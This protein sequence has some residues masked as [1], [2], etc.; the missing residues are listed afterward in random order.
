VTIRHTVGQA[1][2]E[3]LVF[4]IVTSTALHLPMAVPAAGVPGDDAASA[5]D[6]PLQ[7]LTC[8]GRTPAVARDRIECQ[9]R[10]SFRARASVDT[11]LPAGQLRETIP[12]M[13]VTLHSA[14]GRRALMDAARDGRGAGPASALS[15]CFLGQARGLLERTGRGQGSLRWRKDNCDDSSDTSAVR[16]GD[17]SVELDARE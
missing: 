16:R 1:V 9:R 13:I 14:R 15:R 17:V 12:G 2:R 7:E 11:G 8:H 6:E 3:P 5:K 4:V 10:N